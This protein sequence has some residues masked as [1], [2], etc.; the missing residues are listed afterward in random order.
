VSVPSSTGHHLLKMKPTQCSKTSAFNTQ[1]LGKY[2]EDILSLQLHVE[3]L[4][5]TTVLFYFPSCVC[6]PQFGTHLFILLFS[7]SRFITPNI[8]C[9]PN[10]NHIF[11][12]FPLLVITP[13]S[14]LYLQI[15]LRCLFR[16]VE[17]FKFFPFHIKF[18]IFRISYLR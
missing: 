11:A 10:N 18:Y 16:N 8:Y 2:P 9:L 13:M 7:F 6:N 17:R 5:T 4:K 15:S 1:T 12:N 14:S 3:S